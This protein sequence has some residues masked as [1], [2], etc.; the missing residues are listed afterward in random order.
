[1]VAYSLMTVS[2][3]ASAPA[4]FSTSI[5]AQ[6]RMVASYSWPRRSNRNLRFPSTLGNDARPI[7]PVSTPK[8]PAFESSSTINV[9]L[10][11]R[12]A[13]AVSTR[14]MSPLG[15]VGFLGRGLGLGFGFGASLGSSSSSSL[16]ALAAFFFGGALAFAA[17][18]LAGLGLGR[19]SSSSCVRSTKSSSLSES[20]M[21]YA[22]A[23]SR[24][25]LRSPAAI[26]ELCRQSCLD[27]SFASRL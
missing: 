13:P 17:G 16:G 23:A 19:S 27:L 14:G 24:A 5:V 3:L 22:A 15:P 20:D 18:F 12:P 4:T 7:A 6:G 25:A 21:V 9:L 10:P 1:M 11:S 26:P 8:P 2:T